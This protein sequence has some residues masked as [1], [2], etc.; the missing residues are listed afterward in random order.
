MVKLSWVTGLFAPE[1][2][3]AHTQYKS[4]LDKGKYGLNRLIELTE[5][6]DKMDHDVRNHEEF[7]GLITDSLEIAIWVRDINGHFLYL[8]KFCANMILKTTVDKAMHLTDA[9]FKNDV[10]ASVCTESDGVVIKSMKS[11]RFIEHARY[12]EYDLWI[13]VVKSPL[14]IEGELV[15]VIGSG[16]EITGSIP[17]EIRDRFSAPK[18]I[19][20]DDDSCYCVGI[21]NERRKDSL[22]KLLEKDERG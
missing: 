11:C 21:N 4:E 1:K 18:Y 22:V 14:F 7:L 17:I 19:E 6:L 2:H 15:G 13:D 16:K 20:I 5:R 12:P 8:N 3:R 10:L 9:D